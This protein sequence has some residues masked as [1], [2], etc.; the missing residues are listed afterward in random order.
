MDTNSQKVMVRFYN[1]S[2]TAWQFPDGAIIF[3]AYEAQRKADKLGMILEQHNLR[4]FSN[5][6]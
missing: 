5:S 6:H 3:N 1:A 2:G 4:R